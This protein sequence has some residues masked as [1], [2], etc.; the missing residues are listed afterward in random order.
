MSTYVTETIDYL[1]SS[2]PAQA[3]FYQAAEEVLGSLQ[4]LL[5]RDSRYADH[6]I[7]QR[8]I[9]P[10][11]QILFRVTWL[12]DAGRPQVNKGYRVQFNSALGPYKGGLRFHPSVNAGVIKFLGF[13]QIFK[14]ALTGLPIGGA[15]GGS[16]FDPKGRSDNEVMRFCQSFMTELYR[17]IGPTVDVPAGDIGVGGREIGYLYGQYKRLTGNY[18]GVLTGKGLHWGG[19]LARREATGYGA[20]YFAQNM[21]RDRGESLEGKTC[22]V[23]GAGNVAIYTIEKLLDIGAKPVTASDSAGMIHDP[24]GIDVAWLKQVK[25]VE[26]ERLLRYLDERPGATYTPVAEYPAGRNAVWSVPCDAAFPSATQNELNAADAATLLANGCSCVSEG[27]NMP[28]SAE[29]TAAFLAAGIAYG[30]AKAANAGGVATSQLEMSQNASMHQWTFEQVDDRLQ[31][32]MRDIYLTASETAA[33]FDAPGNLVLGANI[34]GFR[35]VADAMIDQGL[36]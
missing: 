4:E 26:R 6:N 7:I 16:N 23:S 9:E 31:Q 11:R 28:S 32:I 1:M 34:A 36:V 22:A 29:A 3:D 35:R 33:E 20:V 5:K 17:H 2:S 8:I 14:N 25:E 30:P 24:D 12:D 13:E 15:K 10:E 18:E 19:S 21:L 27:A